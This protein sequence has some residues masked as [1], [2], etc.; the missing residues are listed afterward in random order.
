MLN[1][2]EVYIYIYVGNLK[3]NEK[4]SAKETDD[5]KVMFETKTVMVVGEIVWC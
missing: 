3:E 5:G 1:A 4:D 2:I